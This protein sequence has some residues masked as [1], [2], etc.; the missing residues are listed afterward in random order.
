MRPSAQSTS[1]F[2]RKDGDENG[3]RIYQTI[4][5]SLQLLPVTDIDLIVPKPVTSIPPQ[6][7]KETD[8]VDTSVKQRKK[9]QVTPPKKGDKITT[10]SATTSNIASGSKNDS[11][12]NMDIAQ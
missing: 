4:L 2:K 9:K 6:K 10:R 7:R 5:H 11:D 3:S 12:V 1:A 8:D